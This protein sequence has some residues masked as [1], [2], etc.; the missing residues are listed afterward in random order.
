MRAVLAACLAAALLGVPRRGGGGGGGGGLPGAQAWSAEHGDCE[1]CIYSVHQVQYGSLPSCGGTTKVFSY[2]ACSQVVQ[3]MLAYAH[4]VM[5]LISYGCYQ[6]DPYRGWQTVKPCPAHVVCGRLPN[7]YEENHET[8]CP[9]DFHFRFPHALSALNSKPSNPLLPAA[10][11]QYRNDQSS[12]IMQEE[13]APQSEPMRTP[14]M[15]AAHGGGGG[16]GGGGGSMMGMPT[17][18]NNY[19]FK[20]GAVELRGSS[21]QAFSRY[22]AQAF[23][24]PAMAS[25]I[26]SNIYTEKT[27]AMLAAARPNGVRTQMPSVPASQRSFGSTTLPNTAVGGTNSATATSSMQMGGGGGLSTSLLEQQQQQQQRMP[28]PHGVRMMSVGQMVQQQRLRQQQQQP[29]PRPPQQVGVLGAQGVVQQEVHGWPAP[30]QQQQQQRSPAAPVSFA[31]QGASAP[32]QQREQQQPAAAQAQQQP[33]GH[34]LLSGIH[35]PY[36]PP[37]GAMRGRR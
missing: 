35:L 13:G 32:R 16:G 7:I 23:P 18:A 20:E 17:D 27:N 8:M 5:H 29:L 10:I 2:S 30:Q 37:E 34:S 19:R 3:S 4:D 25:G 21:Q 6:Y 22:P 24:D 11:Q 31:E 14:E 36:D 28:A 12:S 1:L 33:A 26:P 9:T 15:G